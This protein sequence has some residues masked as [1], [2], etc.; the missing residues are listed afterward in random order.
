MAIPRAEPVPLA[1]AEPQARLAPPDKRITPALQLILMHLRQ[2]GSPIAA[3]LTPAALRPRPAP[4]VQVV[5]QVRLE[6]QEPQEPRAHRAFP[7]RLA[8]VVPP[9]RREFLARPAQ[10][11][12]HRT[13]RILAALLARRARLALLVRLLPREPP[14]H[15]E[16]LVPRALLAPQAALLMPLAPQVAREPP[17]VQVWTMARSATA[18]FP[19]RPIPTC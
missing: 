13:H 3:A 12:A 2:P 16:Q 14:G 10:P 18:R 8:L 15:L 9:A 5:Q 17:E 6:P 11:E 19:R 1:R 4:L 7:V